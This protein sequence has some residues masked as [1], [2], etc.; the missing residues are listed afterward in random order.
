MSFNKKIKDKLDKLLSS[1][2]YEL[3][4]D[5]D[6]SI[7]YKSDNL[8]VRLVYNIREQIGMCWIGRNIDLPIEITDRLLIDFFKSDRRIDNE[9]LESFAL[10][11]YEFFLAE[12]KG[13]LEG[14]VEVLTLVEEFIRKKNEEYT[15]E[16]IANRYL[17]EANKAWNAE[18]YE[19]YLEITKKINPE[20]LPNSIKLKSK[21]ASKR[22]MN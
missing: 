4:E 21:I 14:N 2:N 3:L 11:I 10:S 5:Q 7:E 1:N 16:I 13:L 18:K 17:F 6:N 20:N 15:K 9:S 12:G 22:L 8:A 19:E